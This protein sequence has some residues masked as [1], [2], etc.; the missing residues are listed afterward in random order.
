LKKH[1]CASKRTVD[2]NKAYREKYIHEK[3]N[4]VASFF[5]TPRSFPKAPLWTRAIAT[6]LF[7]GTL[8]FA[9]A[10]SLD[11]WTRR[12][13]SVGSNLYGIAYGN[14]KY[15]CVGQAGMILA[16]SNGSSWQAV[17]SGITN[18]LF[19]VAFADGKYVAAGTRG[20]TLI[21]SNC[22]DWIQQASLTTNQ[23]NNVA[24]CGG[25]FVATGNGGTLLTS[26][27]GSTWQAQKTGT[28][29]SLHV[30]V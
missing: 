10:D 19:G 15:V 8:P 20:L 21:S 22:V 25:L 24:H 30:R 2:A 11:T 23:L 5:P 27:D 9:F 13:S 3:R 26:A 18:D 4:R 6:G 29:R 17:T 1:P 16:S 28:T 12:E 14:R 7:L